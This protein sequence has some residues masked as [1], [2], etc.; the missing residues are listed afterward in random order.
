MSGVL[1]QVVC[2]HAADATAGGSG[3][4]GGGGRGSSAHDSAHG[5]GGGC[6]D[7][8]LKPSHAAV[9]NLAADVFVAQCRGRGAEGGWRRAA[10]FPTPA[11]K[12]NKRRG[13][14]SD[15][16][17]DDGGEG[18]GEGEGE[19]TA[20]AN[21]RRR[22]TSADGTTAT[23]FTTADPNAPDSTQNQN[24]AARPAFEQSGRPGGAR[25]YS[26]AS[27]AAVAPLARLG[28]LVTGPGTSSWGPVMCAVLTRH[29][30][31]LPAALTRSWLAR[32]APALSSLFAAG[33]AADRSVT[34][35][36]AWVMRCLQELTAVEGRRLEA[37]LLGGGGGS[38]GSLVSSRSGLETGPGSGSR[39]RSEL[40]RFGDFGDGEGGG[41]LGVGNGFAGED[42]FG[43][44][45]AAREVNDGGAGGL[46]ERTQGT[47]RSGG[48]GEVGAGV[49]HVTVD[50]SW[51]GVR[52]CLLQWLP[53][54]ALP[55]P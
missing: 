30:T 14:T 55:K 19:V 31:A 52:Q 17:G 53:T 37:A 54:Y 6:V 23:P 2:T 12:S 4:G 46:R 51:A 15:G 7:Y 41:G 49:G 40:G 44:T 9:C 13:R 43:S 47:G 10:L 48:G 26:P 32:L 1:A 5:G 18:E 11:E 34:A 20:R 24:P 45:A 42:A 27:V 25:S 28:N 38:G 36:L 3:G 29:G 50:S 22:V 33:A 39:S 8:V 21:Q 16:D 35:R